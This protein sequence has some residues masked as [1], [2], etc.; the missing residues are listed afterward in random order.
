LRIFIFQT[1]SGKNFYGFFCFLD[2]RNCNLAEEPERRLSMLDFLNSVRRA[3]RGFFF[4]INPTRSMSGNFFVT[5]LLVFGT[6]NP[7]TRNIIDYLIEHPE[8]WQETWAVPLL[9]CLAL[10]AVWLFFI[11]AALKAMAWP[12]RI[13]II[14][15][16]IVA[17]LVPWQMGWIA[18]AYLLGQWASVIGVWLFLAFGA[19]YSRLRARVVGQ[20]TVD[21]VYGDLEEADHHH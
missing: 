2:W 16:I 18:D 19:N 6:W 20:R 4:Y 13:M 15:I 14:G 3:L 21:H 8:I 10:F 1:R 17:A 7:A 5:A 11:T 12:A 9:G